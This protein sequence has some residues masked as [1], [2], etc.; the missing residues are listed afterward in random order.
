MPT[1]SS[2]G[3]YSDAGVAKEGFKARHPCSP[4]VIP[5][6]IRQQNRNIV[7]FRDT[8]AMVRATTLAPIIQESLWLRLCRLTFEQGFL[9]LRFEWQRYQ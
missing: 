4:D 8:D 2:F 1:G 5:T 6:G 9:L 7:L 3:A